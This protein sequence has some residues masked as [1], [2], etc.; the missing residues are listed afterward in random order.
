[1][2]ARRPRPPRPAPEPPGPSQALEIA[3]RYL[4]TRPRTAWEVRRRLARTGASDEVIATTLERLGE[5]GLVDDAAFGRWWSEQRDRH[6]PRGHRMLEAELRTK[7]VPASVIEALR[8]EE[9]ERRPEDAALPGTEEE[10][11]AQALASHLRGRP[12]PADAKGLQR[13]GMYLMRRGFDPAVARAAIRAYAE[14]AAGAS[15]EL[16]DEADWNRLTR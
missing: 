13:L 4:A 9:P 6:S 12:V 10:R 15:D 3:A 2:P 14:S 16:V 8:G 1:M 7:G 11:A 5:L